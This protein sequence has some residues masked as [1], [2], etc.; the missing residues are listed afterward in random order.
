MSRRIWII[1]GI[2]AILLTVGSELAVGRLRTP[3][4]CVQLV[5]QTDAPIVDLVA[6]Y[7]GTDVAVK[8]LKRGESINIWFTAGEPGLL[9]LEF[10]Q[11]GNPVN[12]FGVPDF[13][14]I[15]NRRD[16]LK[17]SL[18]IR[19]NLIERSVEDDET[20]TALQNLG[21]RIGGWIKSQF[22]AAP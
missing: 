22:M 3:K 1:L 5:N 15:Q 4:G 14:P 8:R 20:T 7:N 9:S 13:D 12:G 6:T 18:I 10:E 2:L 17:L 16:G 19:N 21:E 11:K